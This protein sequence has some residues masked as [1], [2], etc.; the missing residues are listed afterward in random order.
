[1][2]Q[3]ILKITYCASYILII[4]HVVIYVE[5]ETFTSIFFKVLGFNEQ[6]SSHCVLL[7]CDNESSYRWEHAASIFRVL[8]LGPSWHRGDQG[9]DVAGLCRWVARKVTNHSS[10]RGRCD[11]AWYMTTWCHNLQDSNLNFLPVHCTVRTWYVYILLT[12]KRPPLVC[13]NIH[14]NTPRNSFNIVRQKEKY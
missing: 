11:R 13:A 10:G 4:L 9:E 6:N 1:M 14:K 12:F 2:K 8:G 7:G 5:R 3:Y